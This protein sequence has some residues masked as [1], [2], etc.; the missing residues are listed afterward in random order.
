MSL[1]E[2]YLE[3]QGGFLKS[4]KKKWYEVKGT[5]I[6][7]YKKKGSEALSQIPI[8]PK[9]T[10]QA[11]TEGK[12]SH[13]FKINTESRAYLFAA[14][15]DK[16]AKAWIS[17][18]KELISNSSSSN[19]SAASIK[20]QGSGSIAPNKKLSVEDFDVISVL[21]RGTYGKVQLVR[22][23]SNAQLYAMKTMSKRR[24]AESDQIEQTITERNVLTQ[25][26]HPFLVGAHYS[27]Q[28]E[29]KIF[30]VLDYVPGG[31]LFGR[32]KEEGNFSESRVKLYSAELLLGLGHLHSL[33]L[34]YRDLKPE[35]ILVDK[36]GHIRIT[37]FG[38]AKKTAF[39]ETTNTFCG[40]PEYIAPEMLLKQP[41]D[42]VV[43][44]WSFGI[45]IFE[46]LTG[47]PPFYDENVNTMY[48]AILHVEVEYPSGMSGPVKDLISKLLDKN[49]KTRLGAGPTDAEEIKAHPFFNGIDWKAVYDKKTK[50]EWV[51]KLKNGVDVTNFDEEF[52]AEP[53][54]FSFED[55]TLLDTD[56][57]SA[58]AG[59][60]CVADSALD[61]LE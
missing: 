59:F 18:I 41:Y 28:N 50:P 15:S 12:K 35:N 26:V 31:E 43:D 9:Y 24:L 21:G 46:M 49:P 52:L 11:C 60:T 22:L 47:L 19:A 10:V 17:T 33:G 58:F 55:P 29:V 16:E 39:G 7:S 4:W 37:D 27:F 23:K 38:L 3:K 51:P 36:E 48:K 32:L 53:T 30:L 5:T 56:T 40:T 1:K 20:P 44:W 2:G 8:R 25:I 54:G 34:V 42:K 6:Y 14:S 61:A 57:Q 13:C 45:L